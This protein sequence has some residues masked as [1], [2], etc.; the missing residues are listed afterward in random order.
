MRD[1][2]ILQL[3]MS[4]LNVLTAKLNDLKQVVVFLIDETDEQRG[5]RGNTSN[6]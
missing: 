3:M 5:Q 1:K 2:E 4:E 6:A